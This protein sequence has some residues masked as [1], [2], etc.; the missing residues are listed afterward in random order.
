[1]TLE[2]SDHDID[3]GSEA[4]EEAMHKAVLARLRAE[5]PWLFADSGPVEHLDTRCHDRES[6][7]D[8]WR[9]PDYPPSAA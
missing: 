3:D 4:A 7:T 1:M 2:H 8:E 6:H 9:D 5:R